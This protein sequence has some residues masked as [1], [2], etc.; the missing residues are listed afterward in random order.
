MGVKKPRKPA[1][2]GAEGGTLWAEITSELAD[3]GLIPTSRERRWLLDACREA[4]LIADLMASLEG[5]PHVVKGSQN[6]PVAHPLIAEIRQHRVT[7]SGLL[8][9]LKMD[10]PT[11]AASGR[12]SRTTAHQARAAAYARHSGM[13]A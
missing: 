10:D 12:G 3:D 11:E 4:D 8:A 1:G 7:L 13:G 5:E 6:Q 9:R 2:L